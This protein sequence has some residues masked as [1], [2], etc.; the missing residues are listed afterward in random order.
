MRAVAGVVQRCDG[1]PGDATAQARRED[2]FEL[3]SARSAV[4]AIPVRPVAAV[5]SATAMAT[6]SSSSSSSGGRSVPEVSR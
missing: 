3:A 6:A 5:R 2:L 4:S 1:L